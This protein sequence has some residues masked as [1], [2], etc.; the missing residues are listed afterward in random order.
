MTV[1]SYRLKDIQ[2]SMNKQLD[3]LRLV[4][5]K[6]EIVSEVDQYDEGWFYTCSMPRKYT[7][8]GDEQSDEGFDAIAFD[9]KSNSA[10]IPHV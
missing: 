4:V 8:S 10:I 2:I 7:F 5:Q 3:L 1:L 6:M 9:S